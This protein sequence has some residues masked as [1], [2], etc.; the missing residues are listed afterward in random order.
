MIERAKIVGRDVTV[1]AT[2]SERT[3]TAS[4]R[5]N[6][7]TFIVTVF[8]L[9]AIAK[10]VARLYNS[11]RGYVV[12]QFKLDEDLRSGRASVIRIELIRDIRRKPTLHAIV[13]DS[14]GLIDELLHRQR[15]DK[16]LEKKVN[17]HYLT[18]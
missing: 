4:G 17:N 16:I 12:D 6:T 5:S 1:D 9:A 11:G 14:L 13:A 10:F 2:P 3:S 18:L 15:R 7:A 8:V